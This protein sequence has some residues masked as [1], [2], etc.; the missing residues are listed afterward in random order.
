[1]L[2]GLRAPFHPPGLAATWLALRVLTAAFL[3]V[4]PSSSLGYAHPSPLPPRSSG[5]S[6]LAWLTLTEGG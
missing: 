6:D 1:M 3:L 2:A 5:M 4:L